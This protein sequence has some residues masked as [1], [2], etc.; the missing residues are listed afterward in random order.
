MAL[1]VTSPSYAGGS[2][3]VSWGEV[4]V[5]EGE[6]SARV[7]KEL[8]KL[9]KTATKRADWGKRKD[10]KAFYALS[11]KV[12]KFEWQETAGVVHLDVVAVGKLKG[13]AGVKTKIRVGGKPTDRKKLEKDGLRIVAEGLVTRLA[14]LVRRKP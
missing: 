7:A 11:A 8:S 13:G 3:K 9:L 5:R 1:T 12:T 6:D 4:A 14:E 2:S 10:K